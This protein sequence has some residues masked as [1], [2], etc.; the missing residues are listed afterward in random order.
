MIEWTS[1]VLIL[2]VKVSDKR[3]L[4]GEGRLTDKKI[5]MLQNYVGFAIHS[6]PG[7]LDGMKKSVSAVV[8]HIAS[9]DSNPMPRALS[10][11]IQWSV[12]AARCLF[13]TKGE[14][15]KLVHTL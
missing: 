7:N 11:E 9:T 13:L 6:N 12:L 2:H 4:G 15:L 14:A 5:D 8:D 10:S 3:G 1:K